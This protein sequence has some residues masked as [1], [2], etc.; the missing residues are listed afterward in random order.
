[1][2]HFKVCCRSR[3]DRGVSEVR[4]SDET[5]F[6]GSVTD[7]HDTEAWYTKLRICGR[8]IPFKIDT[9]ADISIISERTYKSRSFQ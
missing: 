7:C 2:N 3:N 1:M 8:I 5:Y 9:G 4:D 6:L